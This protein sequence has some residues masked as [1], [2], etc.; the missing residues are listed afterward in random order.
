MPC[1]YGSMVY[2]NGD[3]YVGDWKDGHKHG[4]GQ[5]TERNCHQY[6]RMAT[7]DR[8]WY[9]HES[10]RLDNFEGAW[11]KDLRSGKGIQVWGNGDKYD[12]DWQEGLR[13]GEGCMNYINGDEYNGE[14]KDDV[15]H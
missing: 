12:G 9:T 10:E 13:N 2:I 4:R 7:Y 11:C 1:G 14:W 5:L 15:R 3:K 6:K 8:T